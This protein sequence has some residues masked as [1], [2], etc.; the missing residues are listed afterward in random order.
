MK[1]YH[2]LVLGLGA[3]AA[4]LIFLLG[5]TVFQAARVLSLKD[6]Y[7]ETSA[8]VQH[9]DSVQVRT[10]SL[11]TAP[12]GIPT[13]K[14]K[15]NE[16]VDE[17]D[18]RFNA[19]STDKRVKRLNGEVGTILG[20]VESIWKT[21]KGQIDE[22]NATLEEFIKVTVP[23][24]SILTSGGDGLLNEMSYL[25]KT[26]ILDVNDRYLFMKFRNSQKNII[27]M[28]EA[29][30]TVLGSLKEEVSEDVEA[31]IRKSV[32]VAAAL[33]II[34]I[35]AAFFFVHI[36]ALRL[37]RRAKA[38]EQ[39][40]RVASERDFSR[41]ANVA[42]SDE[43]GMLSRHLN[44]L[45]VSL[46]SFFGSVNGAVANVATLKDDL[47]EGTARS[48]AAVNEITKNIES[49]KARFETLDSAIQQAKAALGDIGHTL[50]EFTGET[51]RQTAS[52][53]EA[54]KELS[55]AV[56]AVGKVSTELGERSKSAEVLKRVVLE[57]GERVQS[58]NEIIKAISREISGIAEI[59]DL[60]D[61][62]SEQTNILSMNAAIESA[63]AGAAGKGFAVVAEEIRKLA[64]ST[65]DNAQRIGA[66]LS[67]ITD[68]AGAALEASEKTSRAF[69]SI[70]ADVVGFV[71]ALEEIAAQAAEASSESVKVAEAIS[72]SI[73]ATKRVSEGTAEMNDRHS[74]IRE[75]M[76]DIKAISD[77]AVLGIT[78]IDAGSREIL[79]GMMRVDEISAQSKERMTA[80]EAAMSG[81]KLEDEMGVAVK[82][83]PKT[84]E[85]NAFP[86]S[87]V[88]AV[89]HSGELSA[90]ARIVE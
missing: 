60:I 66:S 23:K 64:E 40:M 9:W 34:V 81:F 30:M 10:L 42:G 44:S 75:A 14:A 56:A 47:S 73:E 53:S 90:E 59:I 46:G 2:K 43:I 71:S 85:N 12:V 58:T 87:D 17:F 7:A 4:A 77:E 13:L 76:A 70:N 67:S 37:S 35:A 54:G 48:A 6:Y 83:P 31:I 79:N 68:K 74:A 63:H 33:S 11:L 78:E 61:Q 22:T 18:K 51:Q 82:S 24:N 5:F 25:E 32:L 21:T 27:V 88:D 26:G 52:M 57:G 62:I 36:F 84:I 16:A 55:H 1:I 8:L 49:I 29:F 89:L 45:I 69:E 72:D 80:L 20:E 86:K 65:Q 15:W 28:N 41:R 19:A 38:I 3:L 50:A 39:S